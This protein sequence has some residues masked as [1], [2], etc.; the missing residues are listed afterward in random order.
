M[1]MASALS[2]RTTWIEPFEGTALTPRNG[3]WAHR[4]VDA[5]TRETHDQD[6]VQ[7]ATTDIGPVTLLAVE[8]S[9]DIVVEVALGPADR[10]P[11]EVLAAAVRTSTGAHPTRRGPE[12]SPAD[13]APGVSFGIHSLR[14]GPL[15]DVVM[16]RFSVQTRHDLT[17]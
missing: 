4:L 8:G 10:A 1:P 9:D 15:L 16:P 12:L 2:V 6:Q 11:A 17:A 13:E 7:V 5:I 14:E 3:P